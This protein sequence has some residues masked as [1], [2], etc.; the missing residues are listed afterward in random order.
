M[1]ASPARDKVITLRSNALEMSP[2]L[3]RYEPSA[4]EKTFDHKLDSL[5]LKEL[6]QM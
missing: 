6:E 3:V 2:P 1:M 5:T 4:F